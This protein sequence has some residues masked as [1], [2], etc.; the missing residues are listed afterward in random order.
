[1]RLKMSQK[2]TTNVNL[3]VI[4]KTFFFKYSEKDDNIK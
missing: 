1:M 2:K 3:F 4:N